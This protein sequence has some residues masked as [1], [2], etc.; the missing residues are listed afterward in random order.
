MQ[1]N[2]KRNYIFNVAYQLLS[3]LIPLVTIPYLSRVLLPESIGILSYSESIVSYFSLF[4]VLGSTIYAQREIGKVQSDKAGRSRVFWEIQIIRTLSSFIAI[5]AYFIYVFCVQANSTICI[6]LTIEIFSVIVDITWFFQGV[7]EFGKTIVFGGIAKVLNL[8]TI[9]VFVKSPADLWIYALSKSGFTV[10]LNLL[11][12]LLLPKYLVK[13]YGIKPFAHLKVIMSFF[14]PAIATQVYTILDKSMI[15]WFTDSHL[16]NGYYEYAEKIIR[17]SI[18]V[19]SSLATVLVPRVSKAYADNDSKSVSDI[20]GKA[21]RF[22][23]LMSIPIMFGF[24]AVSSIFVPVY[25]GESYGKSIVLMQIFSPIVLFVGMANVIGVSFLIPINKQNVYLISVV[26]AAAL[27]LILNLILIPRMASVGA[28]V[29]SVIAEAISI[30]IQ[31]VYIIRKQLVSKKIIFLSSVKYWIAGLVMLGV[32]L[33]IKYL[34][35]VTVWAL[36]VLIL[37]GVIAYFLMLLIL[38]DSMLLEFIIKFFRTIK[39]KFTQTK[40]NVIASMDNDEKSFN[41]NIESAKSAEDVLFETNLQTKKKDDDV[42]DN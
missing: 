37:L 11:M 23:W 18:V 34:L 25:L 30:T 38:R 24:I 10:L 12:W 6:I 39:A 7:E 36:I 22:V 28:A 21:I 33:G 13:V 40:T 26:V 29:A 14:I 9:F 5:A 4:A 42:L 1:K 15:G 32:V 3:L 2:L 8:I 27:N 31:V 16:E 41:S 19:I 35:P 20:V 17:I